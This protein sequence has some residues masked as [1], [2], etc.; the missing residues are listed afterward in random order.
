M[1][2]ANG[3]VNQRLQEYTVGFAI[4]VPEVFENIMRL[5]VSPL[6]EFPNPL[7]ESLIHSD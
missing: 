6:V 3:G 1:I 4:A 5:K 2:E 7:V